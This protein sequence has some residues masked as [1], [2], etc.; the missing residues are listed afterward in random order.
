MSV[1]GLMLS[2]AALLLIVTAGL[3]YLIVRRI[4]RAQRDDNARM[5]KLS[6]SLMEKLESQSLSEEQKAKIAE[7]LKEIRER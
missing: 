1:E 7:A 3:F 4:G 6:E 5:D 2:A